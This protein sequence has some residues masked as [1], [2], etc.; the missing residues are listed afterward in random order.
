MQGEDVQETLER[1]VEHDLVVLPRV[2]GP[3]LRGGVEGGDLGLAA[4]DGGPGVQLEVVVEGD[5]LLAGLGDE[6]DADLDFELAPS[7]VVV[8]EMAK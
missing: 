2:H 3:E 5:G 8:S 6:V 7:V 1:I 4:P